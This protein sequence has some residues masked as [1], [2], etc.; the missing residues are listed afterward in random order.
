MAL[1]ISVMFALQAVTL[2]SSIASV[3]RGIRK[4][5]RIPMITITASS[6]ISVK[7]ARAAR[8]TAVRAVRIVGELWD[9]LDVGERG[10]GI[11]SGT[12]VPGP[13]PPVTGG[14]A[15]PLAEW[16]GAPRGARNSTTVPR[17]PRRAGPGPEPVSAPRSGSPAP[18]GTRGGR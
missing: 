10:A 1:L 11:R 18:R 12:V 15:L 7:P 3:M 4:V 14:R 9:V 5:I 13:E 16:V 8:R 2:A 6:S 17:P